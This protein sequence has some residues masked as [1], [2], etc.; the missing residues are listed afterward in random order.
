MP[1]SIVM[2]VLAADRPGL[3]S[4]LSETIAARGGSWQESRMARL[5]GQFAG[6]LRVECPEA[7]CDALL[8]ALVGLEAQGI[9]VQAKREAAAPAEKRETL[10]LDVMGNDRPGIIRS[11]SAAIA[12]A[13]GNVE[14]LS[15]SLESA[16]MSG[17]PIFHAKGIVSLA[18]GSDPAVLIAAIENL[19][20]DLSVSVES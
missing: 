2:T 8:A 18:T 13:G 14:D 1:A 19:G 9:S 4:A 3:V 16:P 20:T 15:T 12:G 11:L 10:A 17:H 5:A 6:I 7:E